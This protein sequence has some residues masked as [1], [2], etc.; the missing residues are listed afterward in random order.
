MVKIIISLLFLC[1]ITIAYAQS[2]SN[3]TNELEEVVVIGSKMSVSF[4]ELPTSTSILTEAQINH[5]G[6]ERLSDIEGFIPNLKFSELGEVGAEFISIRGIGVNPLSENRVAV[7]IDDMPFRTINDKLLLNVNQ[8]EVLRGPQGTLYGANTEGGVIV[9]NTTLPQRETKLLGQLSTEHYRQGNRQQLLINT[10]GQLSEN[11]IGRLALVREQ[12]DTYTQN[13]DPNTNNPGNITDTGLLLTTIFYPNDNLDFTLQYN[14]QFNRADGIYEQTYIPMD[15]KLYNQVFSEPNAQLAQVWGVSQFNSLP[16]GKKHQYHMDDIRTFDED[17]HSINFKVNYRWSKIKMV[18]VTNYINKTSE[19]WGAQFELTSFPL[20]NTGGKDSKQQIFQELRFSPILPD[21]LDWILGFSGYQGKRSFTVG[22]K[23]LLIGQKQFTKVAPLKESSMDIAAFTNIKYDITDQLSGTLGL[24]WERAK[25]EMLRHQEGSFFVG[26]QPMGVFPVLDESVTSSDL[27]PK[28][29]LSY[30]F[31]NTMST[32]ISASK[33]WQPGGI[34]DDAFLTEEDKKK[35]LFYAPETIWNYELGFKGIS[36]DEL[37]SWNFSA[38]ASYAKDWHEMN[39]L[40]NEKG[41]VVSTSIII[42][43]AKLESKGMELEL[44]WTPVTD[45]R[46]S[47]GFGYTNSE[48]KYFSA[49][50]SHD[51]TGNSSIL[52][53]KYSANLAINYQMTDNLH[54]Y[55]KYVAYGKMYLD[56]ENKIIQDTVNVVNARLDWDISSFTVGLFAENIFDEY[57]FNGQAFSDFTVPVDGLYFSSPAAPRRI[58]L[59][60]TMEF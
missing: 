36:F 32:Y 25:R 58:G 7:Y 5:A 8:I 3:T 16:I 21:R 49:K 55:L 17:E 11:W 52:M 47:S 31:S 18:S 45:L 24:R 30:A 34:N 19:G 53:P 56:L 28:V 60:L 15:S 6:I 27:L 50:G 1:F 48:Y 42:N 22:Y 39:F 35:G 29:A 20:I 38:F 12:G 51:F 2:S 37:L 14:G 54:A 43:A 33:G 26:G 46:L 4:S 40:R 9:I 10:S 41:E 59:S 23:D 44:A 13:I 57:Y